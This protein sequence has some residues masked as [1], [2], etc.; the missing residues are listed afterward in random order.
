MKTPN[1]PIGIQADKAIF[2]PFNVPS[3]KNNREIGYYFLKPEDNS[4]WHV[5]VGQTFKKIRPTLQSSDRTK[6][7]VK[8]IAEHMIANRA[9]F[10][11]LTKGL[12]KPYFIE[13]H[14]VRDSK[15]KYDFIN[16]CQILADC[17]TGSY[18][19]N[20]KKIPLKAIAWIEDDDCDNLYFLPPSKEPFYSL[21]KTNPGVW[22]TVVERE[23]ISQP[24]DLFKGMPAESL[25]NLEPYPC[26]KCGKLIDCGIE[27]AIKH[28][29]EFHPHFI[30]VKD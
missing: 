1:T 25:F 19:K 24:K 16:A 12:P 11:E 30:T 6:A 28:D 14:F 23:A 26:D 22:L 10:L 3:S 7:Y 17:M 13:L 4:T 8:N 9:K 20:D 5:K 29:D 27:N 2:L 15:H 21:D 18:W